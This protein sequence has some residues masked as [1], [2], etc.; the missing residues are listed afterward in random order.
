MQN[1]I[2][3]ECV[4]GRQLNKGRGDRTQSV[5][6]LPAGGRYEQLEVMP[7]FTRSPTC[8]DSASKASMP[9]LPVTK[10]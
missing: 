1:H 4:R 9:V 10:T 7:F 2:D 6:Q 5:A 8:G 3:V